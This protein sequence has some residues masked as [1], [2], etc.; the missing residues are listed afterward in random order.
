MTDNTRLNGCSAK[1]GNWLNQDD[2]QRF[3]DPFS[4]ADSG[5]VASAEAEGWHPIMNHGL[6]SNL[7]PPTTS[8]AEGCHR[9]S[10]CVFSFPSNSTRHPGS[11]HA[12]GAPIGERG[13]QGNKHLRSGPDGERRRDVG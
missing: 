2:I 13:W 4:A 6:T 12:D 7:P 10:A 1:E 9:A 3:E 8:L 11:D 5:V